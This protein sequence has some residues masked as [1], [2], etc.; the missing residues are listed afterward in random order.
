MII[1]INIKDFMEIIN[2]IVMANMLIK[3]S[4]LL[5]PYINIIL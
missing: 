5:E 4:Y 3:Y 2:Y 1:V